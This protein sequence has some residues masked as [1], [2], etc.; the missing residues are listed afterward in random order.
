MECPHSYVIRK[1]KKIYYAKE[2]K[3]NEKGV[4]PKTWIES[5]KEA[6]SNY[7][8]KKRANPFPRVSK[9]KGSQ[10][11]FISAI[12]PKVRELMATKGIKY[13][14]ALSQASI[15]YRKKHKS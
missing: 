13:R 1:A 11:N 12:Q 3:P 15:E 9:Y 10:G 8:E 7:R 14:E 5:L 4:K 2:N 6:S